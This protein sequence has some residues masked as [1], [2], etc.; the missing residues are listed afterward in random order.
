MAVYDGFFDAV[1]DEESGAYDRAY[2]S[3]DFTGY[4]GEIIGSGVCVHNDP[5]SFKVRLEDGAAVVSPGYL[6]IQGYWL[7]S[8]EDYTIPLAGTGTLAIA[9]HLNTG[10]RMIELE[11]RSMAQSYPDSL[12]LALVTPASATVEDTRYNADICGIIDTAGSLSGKVEYAIHYIDTEIEDK[13][14]QAEADINAQAA[15]LDAKIAEV[16]AVA[17]RIAPPP[18]GSIKFSASQDVDE[19]WLKC[20]GSFINEAD[21]PELV[22][23]LGKLIPSGDKFQ[24]ISNGEIGPQISNGALYGGRMWVYSYAAKKLYG[25]DVEG[26]A[27]VKE[28]SVSSEDANFQ[29]FLPQS[30]TKPLCLSIVPSLTG[31]GTKVFL[32]Q[33]INNAYVSDS[34][35]QAWKNNLLLY[36]ADFS[37]G[38]STLSFSLPFDSVSGTVN[39]SIDYGECIPYVVSAMESGVETFFC[40]TRH[41]RV[42]KWTNRDDAEVESFAF[43]SSE[44]SG[45]AFRRQRTGYN[46]KAKKES[47]YIDYN[48]IS[49]SIGGYPEIEVSS[50]PSG[51]FRHDEFYPNKNPAPVLNTP[52]PINIAG[53]DK[54]ISAFSKNEILW[55]SL[56][57]GK[58]ESVK[59]A[60]T[61]PSSARTFVDAGAYLWGKD[62]YMI[63]VGTGILFS[64][65][66]TGGS[67]GYLDTTSVLGTIMQFGYLDYSEDEG[68]LYL[69]GQDTN[70]NVKVAK[71]VLNTLYDYANDGAWLPMIASDGVPAYIKAKAA[72]VPVVGDTLTVTV[73]A[74]KYGNIDGY[75]VIEFNGE[76]LGPGTYQYNYPGG[77]G[78]FTASV[79]AINTTT[80]GITLRVNGAT[81]ATLPSKSA[82]GT[83]KSTTLSVSPYMASGLTL[84]LSIV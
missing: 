76:T 46:R 64:R 59:T 2:T 18:I 78:T 8:T 47:V 13:L 61:L 34:D 3:G 52:L 51:I 73:E 43:Q 49:S 33:I 69:L 35:K 65:D 15:R 68:T 79:R 67:F 44:D 62:V 16:Q 58:I 24:L 48:F 82:E 54:V 4:F 75:A 11:A 17:D 56:T 38:A 40:G 9:A 71:I 57:E 29:N 50:S 77:T 6:F 74:P 27:A 80:Q 14:A 36:C 23:A 26:T 12:V 53:R 84:Y 37:D 21:Y 60:L 32:S 31:S 55:A 70:N 10:K 45:S 20:D 39:K 7:R 1:Q 41:T 66:L 22:A 28:V 72:D 30:N 19:E 25:V 83:K 5:D 42:I 63:F 81:M